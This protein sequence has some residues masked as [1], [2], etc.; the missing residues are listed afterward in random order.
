M[1]A[2]G[3]DGIRSAAR[4][5]AEIAGDPA[6]LTADELADRGIRRLPQGLAEATGW[7][8]RSPVLRRAMG[9]PLFEAFLAVRRAEAELFAETSEDEIAAQTRWR[10]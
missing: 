3:L 1:I 8:D 7:L 4:L 2:A 6:A 10:W 5:P 9:D